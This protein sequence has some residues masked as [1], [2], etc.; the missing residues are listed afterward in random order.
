MLKIFPRQLS[1]QLCP[2]CR[3]IGLVTALAIVPCSCTV[4]QTGVEGDRCQNC[5]G[6]GTLAM[7]VENACPE[8]CG[9]ALS[10][11]RAA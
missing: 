1:P 9:T 2:H 11:R 3:G 4:S 8:C 7:E 10:R 6:T 5:A